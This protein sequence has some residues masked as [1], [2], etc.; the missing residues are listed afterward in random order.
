MNCP[1][2]GAWSRVLDTRGPRRRRECANEHRFATVEHV[3]GQTG[4]H[5]QKWTRN[6]AVRA[7]KR[8]NSELARIHGVSEARIRQIRSMP[9]AESS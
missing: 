3:S 8:G 6:Q 5:V 1:K 4:N 9:C 2:C 7:D